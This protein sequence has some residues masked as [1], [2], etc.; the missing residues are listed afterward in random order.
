[1]P[2]IDTEKLNFAVNDPEV[3]NLTQRGSML[4][5]QVLQIYPANSTSE[6]QISV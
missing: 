5:E 2:T 3:R 1:M 4:L 6:R